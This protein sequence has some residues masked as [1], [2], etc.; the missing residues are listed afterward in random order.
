MMNFV[1]V[2]SAAGA[3]AAAEI[4]EL[5]SGKTT[6]DFDEWVDRLARHPEA[7]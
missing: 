6:N 2:Q 5:K 7:A 4:E 1:A 3:F